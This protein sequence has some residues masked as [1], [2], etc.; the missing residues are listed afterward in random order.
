M[1]EFRTN[2][3]SSNEGLG[4]CYSWCLMAPRRSWWSEAF[5]DLLEFVGAPRQGVVH[6]V[7]LTIPEME[8]EHT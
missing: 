7:K 6:G 2:L 3:V 5:G 4:T 1:L 8:N